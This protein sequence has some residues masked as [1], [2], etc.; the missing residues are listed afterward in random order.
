LAV[1]EDGRVPEIRRLGCEIIRTRRELLPAVPVLV[2][3]SLYVA[4]GFPGEESARFMRLQPSARAVDVTSVAFAFYR[5]QRSCAIVRFDVGEIV[6][7]C[8]DTL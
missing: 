8:Q 2:A 7:S 5:A 6:R 3:G 4:R 1:R